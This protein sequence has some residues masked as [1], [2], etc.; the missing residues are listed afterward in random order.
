MIE[1]GSFDVPMLIESDY[2]IEEL[3]Y[4]N[5]ISQLDLAVL[6]DVKMQRE[7]AMICIETARLCIPIGQMLK[8]RYSI[9][10]T[11]Q[12]RNYQNEKTLGSALQ[13]W[14]A[15]LPHGWFDQL[16]ML[17]AQDG[18]STILLQRA[19]LHMLYHT[20]IW[21]LNLSKHSL[22]LGHQELIPSFGGHEIAS[23]SWRVARDAASKISQM[24]TNLHHL[25]LDRFLTSTAITSMIPAI[26]MHLAEMQNKS[27]EAGVTTARKLR[28]CIRVIE[29]LRDIYTGAD[30]VA[31]FIDAI[32]TRTTG[33]INLTCEQHVISILKKE[34]AAAAIAQ[35]A[36]S[37]N[38]LPYKETAEIQASQKSALY[39]SRIGLDGSTPELLTASPLLH[40]YPPAEQITA[41]GDILNGSIG[42]DIETAGLNCI[43]DYVDLDWKAT[44]EINFDG[45]FWL[46]ANECK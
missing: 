4:S 26:I 27:T 37:M 46:D 29:Q 40:E 19:I 25:Q 30:S 2:E 21:V 3:V 45:E 13:T 5:T 28:Q 31:S 38:L 23:F 43:N 1:D 44:E 41:P 10:S 11:S 7:L 18:G 15:S 17:D 39:I 22:P 34:L 36:D 16:T 8:A 12:S 33:G 20:A 35:E 14:A 32:L 6:H 9:P 24:I 42:K